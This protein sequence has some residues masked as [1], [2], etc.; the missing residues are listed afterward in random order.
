MHCAE[1]HTIAG[2]FSDLFVAPGSIGQG[3]LIP[4][5][6][7]VSPAPSYNPIAGDGAPLA[8]PVVER[9][10][11][12]GALHAAAGPAIGVVSK[13]GKSLRTNR[14]WLGRLSLAC[15]TVTGSVSLHSAHRGSFGQ[16][17]LIHA[18]TVPSS[19]IRLQV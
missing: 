17:L 12:E 1:T 16:P 2:P 14:G 11:C 9:R 5:L 15:R 7:V 18:A 3:I 13:R 6:I 19:Q 10:K 4:S 8:T